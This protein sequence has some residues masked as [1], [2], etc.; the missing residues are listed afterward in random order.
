MTSFKGNLFVFLLRNRHLLNGRIKKETF[1]QNTSI[2]KFRAICERGANRFGRIPEGIVVKAITIE[3]IQAEWLIP[4][5]HPPDKVIMY[6]HGGGY[7]SGSCNDHRGIV[8]K[9][10]RSAGITNLIYEY[11]L[12][13]E[14]PFP[15]ALDDSVTVYKW[16]LS[17]GY[18][19]ENIL[20]A[21]ESAGGGLCLA[22]LISLKDQGLP[23]PAAAVAI[24]P[25]TDLTCSGA[26]YLTKN[27]V[28]L[29][30][31]NSWTVF[32]KHY[33]G[34]HQPE[35]PLISPLF[36]NLKGLPPL[37]INSG[38]DDEL[39]DDGEQFYLKARQAGVNV[40]FRP[41]KKM[42]HCYPLMAPMFKEATEAMEEIIGFIHL[43][44]KI[45]Q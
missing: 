26:S 7:V 17:S 16:L 27:K 34:D 21:G 23:L 20:I 39:Y 35:D 8:S 28:S 31:L 9:F 24:S 41:G 25:W 33:V 22:T 45:T 37:F 2:P 4:E 42:F 3:G 29:A 36:G 15:A 38:C 32:S 14:H 30:P 19:S 43:H 44:L 11:R 18:K 13:P 12:A 40:S 10:A 1:D 6:V 5:N